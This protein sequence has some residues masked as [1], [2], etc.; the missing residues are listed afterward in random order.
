MVA[1]R[2]LYDI[3]NVSPGAEPVVIDAAYRALMKKYHPDQAAAMGD[4]TSAAEINRAF[5][6]L[7]DPGLRADYDRRQWLR[8]QEIILVQHAPPPP[9]RPHAQLFGWSGWV[10]AAV[11]GG[12]VALM[13]GRVGELATAQAVA[14]R[15]AITTEPDHRSQ[16]TLP[17]DGLVAPELSADLRSQALVPPSATMIVDTG[18]PSEPQVGVARPKPRHQRQVR[19]TAS[20]QEKDF[21]ER[22]GYIY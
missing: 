4:G 2:S 15:A 10:V 9:P 21:L 17:N 11:L 16:P 19:R 7:R 20:R 13:V 5:A 3:L 6:T 18:P 1:Q 14:A 12:V 22:E 8:E